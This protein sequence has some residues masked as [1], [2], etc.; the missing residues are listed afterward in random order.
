MNVCE[1]CLQP[2]VKGDLC[3]GCLRRRMQLVSHS[4]WWTPFAGALLG[5]AIIGAIIVILFMAGFV[6]ADK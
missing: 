5:F 6:G 3:V 2:I 4:R 1:D